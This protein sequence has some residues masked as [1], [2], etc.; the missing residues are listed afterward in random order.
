M[1]AGDDLIAVPDQAGLSMLLLAGDQ[2]GVFDVAG[3]MLGATHALIERLG[4]FGECVEAPSSPTA[5]SCVVHPISP[6]ACCRAHELRRCVRS[7][8]AAWKS[9]SSPRQR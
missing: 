1:A 6:A 2:V 8:L 5:T 3:P 9:R 7:S 4:L